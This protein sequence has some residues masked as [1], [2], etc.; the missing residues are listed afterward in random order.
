[1]DGQT[2]KGQL[3]PGVKDLFLAEAAKLSQLGETLRRLFARW[4]YAEVIPP[5]FEYYDSYA[6]GAGPRLREGIYRFLDHR[7]RTLALRPDL[8]IPT[9]RIVG[10]KLYDQPLPLRLCYVANVFRYEEPQAGRQREF[11][12]AGVE[13][14]GAATPQADAE[15]IALSIEALRSVGLRE[16][17]V[18][19]GQ[20]AFLRAI[21]DGLNLVP[22]EVE[23]IKGAIDRKNAAALRELLQALDLDQATRR[24]LQAIPDLYGGKEVLA[25]ARA[26]AR[27]EGVQA[28]IENLAHIYDDLE[29]YGV[30][31]HVILDLGEVRGMEYY[32]GIT[33]ET[34]VAGLGFPICG[35]GRYDDLI[36]QYGPP[37]PA[38][39]FAL[40]ME[41]VL[42]A[43]EQER[44]LPVQLTPEAL[45]AACDH[46][47]CLAQV[48]QMR[49]QGLRVEMD[50]L[51]RDD[52]A[53][54]AYARQR[55]IPRLL[56]CTGPGDL[57]A[58]GDE[59]RTG[60]WRS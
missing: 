3:P 24:A 42:M 48:Q 57:Q 13:L 38:V 28:A 52:E 40:T 35:G 53:L 55:G 33:F 21:L 20:M 25:R 8:T 51:G 49:A 47:E 36:G 18:N 14:V 17:Q 58:M 44:P 26:L 16:F 39:G 19:V 7:G 5:T 43:V 2:F 56:R 54:L 59:E 1:M 6:L 31:Q 11:T 37:L 41:R 45:V 22:A 50:V 4:G 27:D 9:A 23:R 15:V 34:F 12:Q 30:A 10:T 60:P 29:R 32:T 46:P